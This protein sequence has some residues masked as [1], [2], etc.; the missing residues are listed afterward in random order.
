MIDWTNLDKDRHFIELHLCVQRE[1]SAFYSKEEKK[2]TNVEKQN[3]KATM[4]QLQ[5]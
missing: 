3:P 1:I 5:S 2:T 4:L